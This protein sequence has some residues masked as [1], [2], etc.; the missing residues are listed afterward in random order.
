MNTN[1][2][3]LDASTLTPSKEFPGGLAGLP[4]FE[5]VADES[6]ILETKPDG[7]PV[8]GM[9]KVPISYYI[10]E[11]IRTP[12]K[13]KKW[14]NRG[15]TRLAGEQ[16]EF[17]ITIQD[18]DKTVEN[19]NARKKNG[20]LPFIPDTHVEKRD[21][22]KNNGGIIGLERRGNS[23][24]SVMKIVGTSGEEKVKKN[25]V[26]VYLLNG[27]KEKVMDAYGNQYKGYVLDH[28]ALTPNPNQPHLAP[29]ERIAAD[30]D[31][32]T[33]DVPVY[34]YGELS[35][36]GDTSM[37]TPE[38]L[39]MI[40]D[41]MSDEGEPDMAKTLKPE[42]A[43]TAMI[44]HHKGKKSKMA[45]SLSLSADADRKTVD[46]AVANLK[47]ERDTLKS[48]RDAATQKATEAEQ[49]VLSLSADAPRRPDAITTAMYADNVA[50]K[51]EMAIRSGAVS[52]AQARLFDAMV[53]DTQGVPTTLA[54]S[55]SVSGR[56]LGFVLWDTIAKLS[57]DPI[58]TGNAVPRTATVS[59]PEN[60]E[61]DAGKETLTLEQLN[62]EQAAYHLPLSKSL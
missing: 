61:L 25:D 3:I 48:E 8:F 34:E 26:S 16:V 39:D 60:L 22:A 28:V 29:F 24:F 56:P 1:Q 46:T 45:L 47:T 36:S 50:A 43:V 33:R 51:R 54:L 10:K 59:T 49:K 20:I 53:I 2:I 32:S 38:E 41:H 7:T 21:A 23:L 17:P 35:L 13:G 57:G 30:A 44:A 9:K 19:Y 55:A 62:R 11:V 37:C 5:E 12:E 40:K 42:T 31:G 58:K 6:N 18:L 27:D 15:L 4:T 52:E 14:T